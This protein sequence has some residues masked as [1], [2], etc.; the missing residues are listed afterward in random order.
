MVE[1]GLI[2]KRRCLE[3]AFWGILFAILVLPLASIGD[4]LGIYFDACFPDYASTQV[5]RQQPYQVKWFISWPL[6]VQY[7]IQT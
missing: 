2:M 4:N 1:K 6:L 7:I 3:I 5:L